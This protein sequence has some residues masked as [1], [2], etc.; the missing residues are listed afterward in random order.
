MLK[1]KLKKPATLLTCLLLAAC[2]GGSE[3]GSTV[4]SIASATPV[5]PAASLDAAPI[6]GQTGAISN[7]TA[8]SGSASSSASAA[9]STVGGGTISTIAGFQVDA[10]ARFN[11]PSDIVADPSGNLYVF[12]K[13]NQVIR[14]IAASGNVITLIGT[15]SPYILALAMDPAGNLVMLVDHDVLK[16]KVDVGAGGT[17]IAGASLKSYPSG[18]G[19]YTPQRIAFDAQGRLYVLMQYRNVFYV[20]RVDLSGG[21]S[22]QV[23][24]FDTW[25]TVYDMTVDANGDIAISE[26]EPAPGSQ[27]RV[28]F[29]PKSAQPAQSHTAGVIDLAVQPQDYGTLAYDTAGNLYLADASTTASSG[30]DAISISAIRVIKVAPDGTVTTLLNGFPDGGTAPRQVPAGFQGT[31]GVAAG[32]NGDVYI[33]DPFDEAI[34]KINAT[35]SITLVGGKPGTSGNS[36]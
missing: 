4:S 25:G 3:D 1:N 36:D 14:R 19:K 10:S 27:R 28:I 33:A 16:V 5:V 2:G 9:G 24:S 21:T 11:T 35:G 30:T 20:D 26:I 13:G 15:N 12:D 18:P 8:S 22:E 6:P 32:N 29:V 7:S 23:F 34:Y 31:V 17:S